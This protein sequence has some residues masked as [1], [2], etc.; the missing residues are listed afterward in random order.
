MMRRRLVGDLPKDDETPKFVE[1]IARINH[2]SIVGA[3]E[4]FNAP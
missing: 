3:S 2:A 1:A 4:I